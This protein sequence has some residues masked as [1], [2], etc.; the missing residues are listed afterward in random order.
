M[1]QDF[2]VLY[3]EVEWRVEPESQVGGAPYRQRRNTI[4]EG[5]PTWIPGSRKAR[6][7][8]LDLEPRQPQSPSDAARS[9]ACGCGCSSATDASTV[10]T[11]RACPGAPRNARMWV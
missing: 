9:H 10:S 3:D 1:H 2:G 8:G 11:K 4:G 5:K 7:E 6:P